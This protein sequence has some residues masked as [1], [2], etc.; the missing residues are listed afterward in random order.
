MK[1]KVVTFNIDGLPSILDLNELP[2]VFKPFVWIY[3]L[4]KKTTLIYI[5][6]NTNRDQDIL[7]ISKYLKNTKA[8][9]IGV[10]EDFNYHDELMS[11]LNDKYI[12]DTPSKKFGLS[13]IFRDVEI[14][15][16]F[17]LPRF[18]SDGVNMLKKNQTIVTVDKSEIVPWKD[19]YGY[20]SHANDVLT[21][22]GF[23]YYVINVKDKYPINVYVLHM[24]ADFYNPEKCPDVSKDIETRAS[25]MDQLVEF[26]KKIYNINWY[27]SIILGDTNC[28]PKFEWD[29]ENVNNHLINPINNIEGLN[30]FEVTPDSEFVD[31]DRIFV[32]N[33]NDAT[34]NIT[35]ESADYDIN[36]NLSDHKP[37]IANLIINPL[38]NKKI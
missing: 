5:N 29:V 20:V 8:D 9:I 32:I 36:V 7:N 21:T 22:K 37:F 34:F 30:I 1:L 28:S 27:P 2:W 33:T 19:S 26:I 25:Q 11:E 12:S 18:K 4:I 13:N 23:R 14:W 15:S 16:H 10:Q 35:K 6:D 24:D 3:K 31:V 17:P 38:K